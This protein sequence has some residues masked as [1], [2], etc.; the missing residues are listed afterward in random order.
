MKTSRWMLGLCLL[1]IISLLMGCAGK[2][3]DA[4]KL[5]AE[6]VIIM[7]RYIEDLDQADNAKDVASAMNRYADKLEVIWPKMR[8]LSKKYPELKDENSVPEDL[9]KA[10]DESEAA[11]MKMASSFMKV[12][13]HLGDAEV[14][15]AQERIATIMA[16]R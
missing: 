13:P 15:K 6:F 12:A 10:R 14:M 4:K 1:G 8:A 9:K 16:G 3:A 7:N 5:N 11:G 2:Y